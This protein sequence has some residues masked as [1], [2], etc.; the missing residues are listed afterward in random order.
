[1]KPSP[2]YARSRPSG[3]RPEQFRSIIGW[4][5]ELVGKDWDN[6]KIL[7]EK[8]KARDPRPRSTRWEDTRVR[9]RWIGLQQ[10]LAE[11]F[12]AIGVPYEMPPSYRPCC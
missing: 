1:M 10:D 5:D 4:E 11:E 12:K 8:A 9:Q 2:Y 3:S 6:T 7:I